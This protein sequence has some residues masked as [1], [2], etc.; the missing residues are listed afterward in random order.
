MHFEFEYIFPETSTSEKDLRLINTL[1]QADINRHAYIK[2][3]LLLKTSTIE[4]CILSFIQ[5]CNTFITLGII[6][7]V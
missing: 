2:F 6:L 5:Q 7:V 3:V 1:F 4:L